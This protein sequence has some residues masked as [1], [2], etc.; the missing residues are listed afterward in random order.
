[1]VW[2]PSGRS[3]QLPF[4]QPPANTEGLEDTE[5]DGENVAEV[6]DGSSVEPWHEVHMQLDWQSCTGCFSLD[7]QVCDDEVPLTMSANAE[8]LDGGFRY[9]YLFTWL[10]DGNECM[11]EFHLAEIFFE[12]D[13]ADQY[14]SASEDLEGSDREWDNDLMP[15]HDDSDSEAGYLEQDECSTPGAD[16]GDVQRSPK[17]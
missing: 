5:S 17:S 13:A 14:H 10:E 2:L 3:V 4:P 8:I 11:P 7:G 12:G 16:L 6:A 1:M 15:A 9:L